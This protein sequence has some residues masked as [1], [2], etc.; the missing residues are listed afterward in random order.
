M[1][2][3]EDAVA[4]R[5]QREVK[6]VAHR[7]HLGHCLEH[8]RTHVLRVRAGEATRRSPSISPSSRSSWANSGPRLVTSRPY[9]LTFWPSSVT[10]VTPWSAHF[11]PVLPIPRH[12]IG[13][14]P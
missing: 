9:E 14:A 1:H 3:R 6:V 11:H 13:D 12:Q 8:I 4:A 5:L 2:R 10:S 7:R